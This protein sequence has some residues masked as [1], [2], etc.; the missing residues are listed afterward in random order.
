MNV[1]K[2]FCVLAC[3]ITLSV[4]LT[5]VADEKAEE[6]VVMEEVVVTARKRE[7]R[8]FEVP[9]SVS[10][11]RGEKFDALR[12]SGMDVRFFAKPHAKFP[13]GVVVWT[14]LSALLYPRAWQYG[15]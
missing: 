14:S 1:A 13:D 12:S 7:Q 6:S 5:V 10:T 15:L 4:S 2:Q 3:S 11:V 9:L 8:S